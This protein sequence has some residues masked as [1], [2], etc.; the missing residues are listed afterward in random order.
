MAS[1]LHKE[2]VDMR[3]GEGEGGGVAPLTYQ[4]ND[5][6]LQNTVYSAELAFQTYMQTDS[7]TGHWDSQQLLNSHK[8]Q[9]VGAGLREALPH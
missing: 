2:E 1:L 6:H 4:R 9:T 5:S 3:E 7:G 8:G